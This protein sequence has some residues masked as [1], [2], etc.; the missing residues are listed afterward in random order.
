MSFLLKLIEKIV[1]PSLQDHI[2]MHTL[3]DRLQPAHK[4]HHITK[5]ALVKIQND[6]LLDM[7][8]N[9]CVRLVQLNL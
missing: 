5:T 8:T 1:A 7:N 2:D 6:I 3:K 9:Q 4:K